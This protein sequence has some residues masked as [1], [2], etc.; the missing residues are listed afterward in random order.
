MYHESMLSRGSEWLRSVWA[1]IV[2]NGVDI[3]VI[4]Q[5]I[6][7][8]S[9]LNTGAVP[10]TSIYRMMKKV[11]THSFDTP[12]RMYQRMVYEHLL[13]LFSIDLYMFTRA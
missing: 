12:L 13:L 6:Y 10:D 3:S 1:S 7:A 4:N 9:L 2:L 8:Q 11:Q 5:Q